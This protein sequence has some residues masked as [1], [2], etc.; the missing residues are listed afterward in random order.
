MVLIDR[1]SLNEVEIAGTG[2]VGIY[3]RVVLIERWSCWNRCCWDI[4]QSGL[5]REVAV[6]SLFNEVQIA[7]LDMAEY[8]V[9]S[10][11]RLK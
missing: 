1:W 6:A 5:N 8:E 4:W 11:M 2:A 7:V 9:V 3:G 10:L